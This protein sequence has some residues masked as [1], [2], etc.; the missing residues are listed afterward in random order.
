M[1]TL[2]KNYTYIEKHKHAKWKDLKSTTIDW[3]HKERVK[4]IMSTY[5]EK[6]YLQG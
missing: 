2:K 3:K 5:K 6:K 4:H 1:S